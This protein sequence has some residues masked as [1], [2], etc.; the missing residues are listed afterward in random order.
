MRGTARL[1]GDQ[2]RVK[3]AREV[4]DY[5]VLHVEDVGERLIEPFGPQVRATLGV[6][7]LDV[8]PHS[9]PAALNAALEHVAHIELAA[10]RPHIDALVLVREGGIACDDERARYPRKVG[11]QALGD[12][13]DEIALLGIGADVGEGQHDE[14]QARRLRPFPRRNARRGRRAPEPD[15]NA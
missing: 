5:F 8:D 15:A 11:R 12:A 14:G 3:L 6:D 1:G 7:E 2:C 10:D 13:V 9:G 4:R